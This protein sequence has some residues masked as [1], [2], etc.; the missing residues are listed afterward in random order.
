LRLFF[1][2]IHYRS[3]VDYNPKSIEDAN[4]VLH[5]LYYTYQRII[6]AQAGKTVVPEPYP[7]ADELARKFY[8]AMDD[9]FNTALGLSYVLELSKNINK[10]VDDKD[11]RFVPLIAYAGKLFLSLTDT[12]GLLKDSPDSLES[13]EKISH[14][15]RMGLDALFIENAIQERIESRKNKDYK[16]ADEIRASLLEKGIVLLDT[17]KGTEWRIKS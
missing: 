16:R 4:G 13:R 17:P 9:D 6:D 14:L 12:L 2:T 7:E 8:D 10:L 5:R 3:P 15:A 1:L 11:E